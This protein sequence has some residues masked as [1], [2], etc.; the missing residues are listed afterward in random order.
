M[1]IEF[2]TVS[3][4]FGATQALF[5]VSLSVEPGQI[6]AVV[7]H[8]GSGKSTLIK[9]LAGFHRVD[10]GRV[11]VDGA[12][13]DTHDP[14]AA[15]RGGVRFVHQNLG[16]I[17][18][19]TV[20]E[21]MTLGTRPPIGFLRNIRRGADRRESRHALERIGCNLDLDTLIGELRPSQRTAVALARALAHWEDARYV[22]LDEPTAVMPK[23]EVANLFQ[24]LRTLA[25]SELGILYVSHHLDEIYEIADTVTVLRNGQVVGTYAPARLSRG[26][27]VRHI[28]DV[29]VDAAVAKPSTSAAL[30]VSN[31]CGGGVEGVSMHVAP[32]EIVGVAGVSGS[33]RDT[34]L[35]LIFGATPRTGQVRVGQADLQPERPDEAIRL[36][37]AMLSADRLREALFPELTIWENICGLSPAARGL[38]R[39]RPRSQ[40]EVAR[41]WIARLNI[42][43]DDPQALAGA[44]S[45]GNQ[46]KVVLA[47]SLRLQPKI[48]LMDEPTQGV[49]VGAR[50]EIHAIIRDI[51]QEGTAVLISSVDEEEL[52]G[53]CHRIAV[54]RKGRIRQELNGAEID[55]RALAT[56]ALE[57]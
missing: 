37:M 15:R 51:A 29:P 54:M 57:N 28:A 36:G 42:L 33:G 3:K 31:L 48:L 53:L 13:L 52:V 35:S 9:V 44:I 56:A 18:S 14:T 50:A 26:E 25:G 23:D 30:D 32:G 6:H 7:G 2:T 20:V 45:G 1:A 12:E 5:D 27:L 40:R 49:D 4:S 46:Q 21:N 10:R 16:L 39:L 11:Q 8:N 24:S 22:V 43:P 19:L 34:L 38:S 17:D 55:E 47:R 41:R